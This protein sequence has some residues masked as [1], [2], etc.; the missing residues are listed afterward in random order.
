MRLA[1]WNTNYARH[2]GGA[3]SAVH[4]LLNRFAELGIET[5]LFTHDSD[6]HHAAGHFFEPLNSGVKVYQNSFC[7]PW[8]FLHR[9]VVFAV[10][11]LKYLKAAVQLGFFLRRNKI[12]VIHLHYVSWDIALLAVYKYFFCYRLA[13]TFRAGEDLIARYPGLSR[14]KIRIALKSADRVTTVSNDL[15]EKLN[16]DYGFSDA[17]YIPNGVDVTQLRE[18][19]LRHPPAGIRDDNFIFCGRFTAQKRLAFLIEAFHQCLKRGCEQVLYLV[20]DGEELDKIKKLVRS[21]G[22]E[23]RVIALGALSHPQTLGVLRHT[24]C[25]LLTS[26]FEGFPQAAMEAMALAKPVIASDV[27]GLR[28]LVMHGDTGYLYPADRQDIF[29]DCLMKISKNKTQ[30]EEMGARG[31]QVLSERYPLKAVVQE[32]LRLYESLGFVP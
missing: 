11:F 20:G 19:A 23:D 21:L 24:R 10:K 27:G 22:I 29:C 12:H 25:L 4:Q 14:L 7:N 1:I 13:V 3:E 15:C 26:S 28:D 2:Y 31:F 9:P 32:Y 16:A 17:V 8:D 30:A 5:F 6:I 18:C